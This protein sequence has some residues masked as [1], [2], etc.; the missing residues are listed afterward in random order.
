MKSVRFLHLMCLLIGAL[1]LSSY[2]PNSLNVSLCLLIVTKIGLTVLRCT[3]SFVYIHALTHRV[4]DSVARY[5][6]DPS[7]Q[8]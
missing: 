5:R 1:D 7:K 3:I 8:M 4:Y 2:K 6:I